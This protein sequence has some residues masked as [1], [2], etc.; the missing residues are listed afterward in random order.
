MA[1]RAR[2]TERFARHNSAEY[3]K[4]PEDVG[5]YLVA[6]FEEGGAAAAYMAHVIGIA[7]RAA[8]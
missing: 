6:A 1:A 4:T 3:L 7:A 5:E 2:E 8:E